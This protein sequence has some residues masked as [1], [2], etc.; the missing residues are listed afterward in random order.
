MLHI[1]S[2]IC[3]CSLFPKINLLLSKKP[4]VYVECFRAF[5]QHANRCL[6]LPELPFI[7]IEQFDYSLYNA[8]LLHRSLLMRY[9]CKSNIYSPTLH[10]V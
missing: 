5:S 7:S 2:K 1:V 4:G 10:S 8:I 9:Q 6:T 3:K